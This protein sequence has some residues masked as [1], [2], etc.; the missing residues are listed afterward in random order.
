[1]RTVTVGTWNAVT[2]HRWAIL[3][4][5]HD[6]GLAWL[7]LAVSD[8]LNYKPVSI[9]RENRVR[10]IPVVN[11]PPLRV[12][13]I[14]TASPK[15]TRTDVRVRLPRELHATIAERYGSVREALELLMRLDREL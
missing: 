10:V 8:I 6:E 14:E 3:Q 13:H 5:A 2:A 9:V 12:V 4:Y 11:L 15:D 1:M 7:R